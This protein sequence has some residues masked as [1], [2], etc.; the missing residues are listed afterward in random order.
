VSFGFAVS[1]GWCVPFRGSYFSFQPSAFKI[2]RCLDLAGICGSEICH[3]HLSQCLTDTGE[4]L[5]TPSF[6]WQ[7]MEAF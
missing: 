7:A 1:L 4:L 5:E 3:F 6:M 2:R